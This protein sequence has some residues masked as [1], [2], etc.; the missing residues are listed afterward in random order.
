LIGVER[1]ILIEPKTRTASM[2]RKGR[3]EAILYDYEEEIVILEG[4]TLRL[5]DILT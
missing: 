2:Y 4:L 1:I 5:I 3:K